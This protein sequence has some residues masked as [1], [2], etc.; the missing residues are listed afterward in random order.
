MGLWEQVELWEHEGDFPR[1]ATVK[2]E[3]VQTDR[4]AQGRVDF[5]WVV[6]EFGTVQFYYVVQSPE[7][8]KNGPYYAPGTF[9]MHQKYMTKIPL[10]QKYK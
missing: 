5:F 8:A 7:N 3:H 4:Q 2:V 6:W 10:V 1:D 9:D